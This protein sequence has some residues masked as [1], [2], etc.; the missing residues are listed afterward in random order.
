MI[1]VVLVVAVAFGLVVG[2]WLDRITHL[3]EID[4]ESSATKNALFPS[5][6]AWARQR[7]PTSMLPLQIKH[8]NK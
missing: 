3:A 6:V 5:E 8:H 4:G 1:R 2:E 7:S